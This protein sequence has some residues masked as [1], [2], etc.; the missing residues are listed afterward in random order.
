MNKFAKLF[1]F[2]DIGQ[3]LVK[4]DTD[5]NGEPEVRLYF[6]PKGFGVCATVLNFTADDSDDE[7]GKA[8]KAFERIDKDTAEIIVR[9]CLATIPTGLASE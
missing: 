2:D 6:Q 9:K 3:V 7:A 1:E 5:E 4:R 8:E